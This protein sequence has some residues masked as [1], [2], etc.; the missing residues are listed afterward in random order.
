MILA[1]HSKALSDFEA[2]QLASVFI[3]FDNRLKCDITTGLLQPA[4]EPAS[5]IKVWSHVND[6]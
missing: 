1:A 4:P 2:C 3:K 6:W 5:H